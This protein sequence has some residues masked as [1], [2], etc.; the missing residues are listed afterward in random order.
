MRRGSHAGILGVGEGVR[1]DLHYARGQAGTPPY[2][3]VKF[4]TCSF[5]SST[6]AAFL[7]FVSLYLRMQSSK[8]KKNDFLRR[9]R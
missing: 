5:S 1:S 2:P 9:G 7:R 8:K 3:T 4:E 6:A